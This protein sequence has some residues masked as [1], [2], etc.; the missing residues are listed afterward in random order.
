MQKMNGDEV[1]KRISGIRPE[2][3]ITII[4]TLEFNEGI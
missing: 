3:K 4:T 2:T 1:V